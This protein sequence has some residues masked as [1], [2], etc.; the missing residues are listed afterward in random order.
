MRWNWQQPDWPHFTWN[1]SRLAK[2]EER[3]LLASGLFLGTVKHLDAEDRDRL[4]V[5]AMSDEAVTTSQIEGEILDR[6]SVQSSIR[7]QLGLASDNRRVKPAEQGI[8]EMMVELYR[9]FDAPLTDATLFAWHRMVVHGRTDLRDVGRYRTHSDPMQVVSGR[10]D[11]PTVHFEAPPSEAVGAEMN[12]Y[13]DWFN[14]TA[15]G[16]NEPLPALT[17]AGI[18]HLY[19]ESIHPFEDGNGRI[20]RGIAEKALAQSL[21]R[22]TLTALA[23]T[24]LVKRRLYYDALEAANKCNEI[25]EWLA[26]FA[27]TSIEAQQRTLSQVEFLIDKTKLLDRLRGQ[28]NSRQEAVLLRMFREGPEGFKGGLSAGNYVSIAKVSPA[29]ATRDLAELVEK[30]ALTRTGE[31]RH[32]RYHL[33]IP[34]RPVPRITID[35]SGEVVAAGTP[36]ISS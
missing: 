9:D 32:T 12:R 16:G 20:G 23:A 17:R 34:L 22:A 8:A 10:L 4:T 35:A 14:R 5:E 19:F 13:I 3:F 24:I 1:G 30:G 36:D 31:R 25:T 11:E 27:A 28:L 29:T 6:D 7:R 2:A 15:P 18:A 33:P 26:W 21:G